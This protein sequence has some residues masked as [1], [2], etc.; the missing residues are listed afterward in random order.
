MATSYSK[1]QSQIALLQRQADAVR[2]SE[3]AGVVKR[4]KD[5]IAT[6]GITRDDLFSGGESG[7]RGTA[8]P[9][10]GGTTY[11]DGQGNSWGGRGP[12]P[13]WLRDAIAGGK[14]LED[15]AVQS[16][17]AAKQVGRQPAAKKSTGGALPIKYRDGENTWTGR[18]S[19][20]RWLR[21]ALAEGKTIEQFQV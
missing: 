18:G 19:Q 10:S 17:L 5:A 9:T 20:P 2:K 11:S 13:R 8:S 1:L 21:A 16:A 3:V 4:I 7:K 15:F 6:Y 14:S 12:R